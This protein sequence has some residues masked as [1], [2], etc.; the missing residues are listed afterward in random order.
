MFYTVIKSR[1][2]VPVNDGFVARR[3]AGPGLAADYFFQ[4]CCILRVGIVCCN[5]Q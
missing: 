5:I 3:V 2:R 4:V 1:G